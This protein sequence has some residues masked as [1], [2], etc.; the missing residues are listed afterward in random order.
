M[1]LVVGLGNPG[2]RY[3]K[4]R[5]NVGFM[6]LNTLCRQWELK[7]H[8]GGSVCKKDAVLYLKP[9]TFMN[10]SGSAVQ[11]MAHYYK[12][13]ATDIIVIYD[14][15]DIAFG[16]VRFRQDGSSGGHNGMKSIIACLGTETIAR[17]KIGI[18]PTD[19]SAMIADTADYVLGK[20]STTE[21]EQL[22][23]IFESVQSRLMSW[24]K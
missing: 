21:L 9:Q 12:I 14:D 7:P 17:I 3:A 10:V 6:F 16:N 1:R 22:P 18:A 5:H 19:S 15:K 11:A 2:T 8:F 4:T 24:L 23:T 13:P 20:F